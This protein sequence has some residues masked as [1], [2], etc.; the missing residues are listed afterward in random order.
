MK[1]LKLKI[2]KSKGIKKTLN[3][4]DLIY[5]IN[6]YGYNFQQFGRIRKNKKKIFARKI[7]LDNADMDQSDLLLEIVD[8][9]KITKPRNFC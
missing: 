6:K 7:T 2:E 4:E 8:F 1:K 3:R 5:D 9:N